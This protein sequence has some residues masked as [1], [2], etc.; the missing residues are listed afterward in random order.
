M[1]ERYRHTQVGRVPVLIVG[2]L[3]VAFVAATVSLPARGPRIFLAF[4]SVGL[5]LIGLFFT[6]LTTIVTDR[7]LIHHHG[8]GFWRKRTP[9]ENIASAAVVRNRWWYGFGIRYTPHGW[10]Y[11]VWGLDAVEIRLQSGRTFRVGTD[12]PRELLAAIEGVV[13]RSVENSR[14]S[15]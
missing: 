14:K 15:I 5:V 7:E 8:L 4:F 9:I 1:T 6:S 3:L 13:P 2:T 12:E 10:L 11:N